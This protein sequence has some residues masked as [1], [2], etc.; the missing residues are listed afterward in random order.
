MAPGMSVEFG[1]ALVNIKTL[2]RRLI[3]CT[4]VRNRGRE[5][6]GR[7]CVTWSYVFPQAHRSPVHPFLLWCLGSCNS[8]KSPPDVK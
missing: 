2:K 8:R 1:A 3:D 6:G 4:Q 5:F 7:E